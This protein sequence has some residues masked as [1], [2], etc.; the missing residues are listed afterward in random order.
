MVVVSIC[1]QIVNQTACKQTACAALIKKEIKFCYFGRQNYPQKALKLS[2]KLR[3]F[4][5]YH[6]S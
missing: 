4:E 2:A 3:Y 5:N 1:L 6:E